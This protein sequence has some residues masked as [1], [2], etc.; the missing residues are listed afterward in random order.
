VA[1]PAAVIDCFQQFSWEWREGT[2]WTFYFNVPSSAVDTSHDIGG[3]AVFHGNGQ[4]AMGY[5]L[6]DGKN[7]FDVDF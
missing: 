7:Q 6:R 1:L 2:P 5:L 4:R 3:L